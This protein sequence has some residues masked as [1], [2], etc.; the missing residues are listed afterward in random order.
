MPAPGGPVGPSGAFRCPAEPDQANR[1]QADAGDSVGCPILDSTDWQTKNITPTE[2]MNT[3]KNFSRWM[4]SIAGGVVFAYSLAGFAATTNVAVGF[5]GGDSFNPAIVHIN[6]GDTIIWNWTGNFHTT[7]S[8]SAGTASGFWD[9][10][11]TPQNTGFSF[12][13]TINAPGSYPFYCRVH[14]GTPFFMTG[15]VTVASVTLPPSVS[16]TNPPDGTTLAEPASFTLAANATSSSGITNVQFFKGAASLGNVTTAPYSVPVNSLTAADYNF[17]AVASD[18]GGLTAT[19]SITVHVVTPIAIVLSGAQFLPNADFRFNY[20][21]NPGLSYIIQRTS[22]LNS[23][24]WTSLSTN[25][26]GSSPVLFDDTTASGTPAFYRVGR[27]P[28]P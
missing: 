4:G 7:T 24:S 12:T 26:A 11:V 25:V 18:N 28:N 27:L 15:L 8:G 9:S 19:N 23:G 10:G 14:F 1:Q 16:I 20:T 21:A 5:G 3:M 6:A 17:S 13:N 2:N 22:S